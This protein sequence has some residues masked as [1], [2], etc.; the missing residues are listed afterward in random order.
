MYL[1]FYLLTFPFFHRRRSSRETPRDSFGPFSYLF[2]ALDVT[3]AAGAGAVQQLVVAAVRDLLD[4][5][6]PTGSDQCRVQPLKIIGCHE[7][8]S[9]LSGGDTVDGVIDI[10]PRI[11]RAVLF[12]SEELLHKV[13]PLVG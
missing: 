6:H 8:Y 12:K 7:H 2:L 13:N 10:Q 4:V 5:I 1:F 11:G 9:A 3:S